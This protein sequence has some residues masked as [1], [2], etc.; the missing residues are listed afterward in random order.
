LVFRESV[1][2][3]PVPSGSVTYGP[4]QI[5]KGRFVVSFSPLVI[6]IVVALMALE[7]DRL[8]CT[9]DGSCAVTHS[10]GSDGPVFPMARLRSVRVDTE[11]GSKGTKYGV[12][13]LGIEGGRDVRLTKTTPDHAAEAASDIRASIA[14]TRP[15]EVVVQGP[16][17]MLLLAAALLVMWISVAYSALK[18]LGRLRLEILRGGAALRVQRRVF[19]VP[20]T[21]HEI[22]LDGV[23]DV[24][25]ETGSLGEA[26]LNRGELPSPAARLVLADPS[27]RARPLTDRFWPGRAVHLRAASDL[28]AILGLAPQP[29]GVEDQLAAL[30]PAT[31]NLGMR[32]A[33]CW[34]GLTCGAL[35]GTGLYGVLGL[36]LGVF[37]ARDGLDGWAVA[38]GAGGGATA[39]ALLALYSTRPRPPR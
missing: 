18:G 25:V 27:G 12:V 30:P 22:S 13:V 35:V 10:L 17:W 39:G 3:G 37:N 33:Y 29:G 28:R 8:V 24:R 23:T 31:T 19:R 5:R 38:I 2:R 36:A 1:R 20:T 32:I 9:P 16:R 15:I 21:S 26:W 6:A 7:T 14:S 4:F 11:T 34:I